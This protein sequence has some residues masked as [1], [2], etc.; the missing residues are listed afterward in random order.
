MD[1]VLNYIESLFNEDLVLVTVNP[2]LKENYY[3]VD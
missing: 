1:E 2:N 3:D